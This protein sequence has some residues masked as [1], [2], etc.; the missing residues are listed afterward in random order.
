[1]RAGSSAPAHPCC[2][3]MCGSSSVAASARCAA[4]L[5]R[6]AQRRCQARAAA[7]CRSR[8]ALLTRSFTSLLKNCKL[9]VLH[10]PPTLQASTTKVAGPPLSSSG[11]RRS[12][13]R[14][15]RSRTAPSVSAACTAGCPPLVSGDTSVASQ[16]RTVPV[17]EASWT[18]TSNCLRSVGSTPCALVFTSHC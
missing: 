12:F 4:T 11:Y 1:M 10:L 3:G 16:Q 2:K 8:G 5:R 15:A 17:G 18:T 14:L 7:L 6:P 9:S 13:R